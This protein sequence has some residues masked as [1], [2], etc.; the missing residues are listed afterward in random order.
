MDHLSFFK[1]IKDG[2]DRSYV[3]LGQEEYVKERA[4]EALKDAA[5]KGANE[6]F[7]LQLI[8]SDAEISTVYDAVSTLPFMGDMRLVV[9]SDP[10]VFTKEI[11][12]EDM[13]M[14]SSMLDTLHDSVCLLIVL[15]GSADKRKKFYKLLKEK[16]Q[17]VEFNTLSDFEA[18]RWVGSTFKKHGKE[19]DLATAEEIVAMVGTSV[20][21][22][23]QETS[24]IISLMGDREKVES[25]DLRVLS[26]SNI[27]FDVFGMIGCFISGNTKEGMDRMY[28]LLDRGDSGFMILGAISS[29]LRGYYQARILMECGDRKPDIIEKLGGGYGAKRAVEECRKI[30]LEQVKK[31]ID[32][33]AYVDYAVKNGLISEKTA[34]EYAVGSAFLD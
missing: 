7:N 27:S 16:S 15:K 5:L 11:G 18:A 9:W 2:I 20:M 21:E 13:D 29:K 25:A 34:V 4:V 10:K 31:G 3:F 24:K 14:L 32:A 23:N 6:D 26:G 30:S 8:G 12:D 1:H 33:L 28:R 17:L 19:I 22:L